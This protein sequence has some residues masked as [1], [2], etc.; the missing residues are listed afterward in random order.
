MFCVFVS[1]ASA[2]FHE[3]AASNVAECRREFSEAD[4]ADEQ[5]KFFGRKVSEGRQIE[6]CRVVFGGFGETFFDAEFNLFCDLGRNGVDLLGDALCELSWES[7]VDALDGVAGESLEDNGD[8]L[9]GFVLEEIG[10]PCRV[11]LFE[12]AA[13]VVGD[14]AFDLLD[15]LREELFAR[16]FAEL[17]SDGFQFV[18]FVFGEVTKER[19]I[20]FAFEGEE[21]QQ[22]HGLLF[23]EMLDEMPHQSASYGREKEQTTA[24]KKGCNRESTPDSSG[25]CESTLC[26]ELIFEGGRAQERPDKETKKE[27]DTTAKQ[28]DDDLEFGGIGSGDT[29]AKKGGEITADAGVVR[30]SFGALSN[31]NDVDVGGGEIFEAARQEGLDFLGSDGWGGCHARDQEDGSAGEWFGIVGIFEDAILRDDKVNARVKHT[32]DLA[33]GVLEFATERHE[34]LGFF[35]RS[36]GDHAGTAV[37]TFKPFFL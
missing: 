36:G 29:N 28:A 10:E 31:E 17:A 21:C 26:A 14:Q 33:Q 3:G 22:K 15:E 12:F 20:F 8:D 19:E 25:L 18:G 4:L 7:L 16:C 32:I 6:G 30:G 37:H 9:G 13:V 34:V 24:K 23:G 5:D 11:V 1:Q 2:E 27:K 35:F